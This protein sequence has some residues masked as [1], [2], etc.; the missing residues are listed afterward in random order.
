MFFCLP[1][2]FSLFAEREINISNEFQY[3]AG[4]DL[5]GPTLFHS[6]ILVYE[7]TCCNYT[8]QILS[9]LLKAYNT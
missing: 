9:F 3:P 5:N 4:L 1:A 8:C 7:D 6:V 2:I